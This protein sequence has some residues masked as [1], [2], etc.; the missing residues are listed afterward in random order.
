[1]ELPAKVALYVRKP[2]FLR[3]QD[4]PEEPRD[5]AGVAT[6]LDLTGAEAFVDPA[7]RLNEI[8]AVIQAAMDWCIAQ[9]T[10]YLTHRRQRRRLDPRQRP[11]HPARF[12]LVTVLSL[13]QEARGSSNQTH[14]AF[15]AA[16]NRTRDDRAYSAS[17]S[18]PIHDR[19][20]RSATE[21]VVLLPANGSNTTSAGSVRNFTKNST[22]SSGIAAGWRATF[23]ARQASWY[24]PR[25]A[26]FAIGNTACGS[27]TGRCREGRAR[28]RGSR[29]RC[30]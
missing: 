20:S 14:A 27:T 3:W 4:N 24:G 7:E 10:I 6:F 1:M 16:G 11:G 8:R 23:P 18:I 22:S 21:P 28:W 15:F 30:R 5:W 25:L 12:P 13:P 17:A 2:E 29:R 19:P 9:D 26:V